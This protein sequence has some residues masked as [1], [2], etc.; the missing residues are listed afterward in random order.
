MAP[1]R[2]GRPLSALALFIGGWVAMRVVVL[3]VGAP[4]DSVPGRTVAWAGPEL[5]TSA[6]PRRT[7][8]IPPLSAKATVAAN[9]NATATGDGAAFNA[10]PAVRPDTRPAPRTPA[11]ITPSLSARPAAQPLSPEEAE[12]EARIAGAF[13]HHMLFMSGQMIA[14]ARR[15]AGFAAMPASSMPLAQPAASILTIGSASHWQFSA[16]SFVRGGSARPGLANGASYGGSQAALN[17]RFALDRDRPERWQI[18]AR[19]SR[20][21]ARNDP[22]E[23]ALGLRWQ[24]SARL[25]VALFGEYRFRDGAKDGPALFAAGGIGPTPIAGGFRLEAYAQAGVAQSGKARAFFDASAQ[26]TR[27]V[28]HGGRTE[29]SAG[30]GVFAGGQ[31]GAAR[32]DI[33]PVLLIDVPLAN[34]RFR[35]N[36]AWRERV[37]GQARPGSGPSVALSTD[38]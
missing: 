26:A 13:R 28:A 7:R 11:W 14:P 27:P 17:A 30:A 1:S 4:D 2:T 10:A 34:S 23:Q 16:Y 3:S 12:V 25:P 15:A 29:M 5:R 32:L 38:F 21:F 36:A 18:S 6:G 35:L 8:K 19:S 37:A 22:F 20:G 31:E 24:P 9:H 33:G